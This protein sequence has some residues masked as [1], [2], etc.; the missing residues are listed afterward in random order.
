MARKKR[1]EIIH[2]ACA[3]LRELNPTS[4]ELEKTIF[5]GYGHNFDSFVTDNTWRGLK[6]GDSYHIHIGLRAD[7]YINEERVET[8][9]AQIKELR[10]EGI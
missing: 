2:E 10:K 1:S 8:L 3:Q 6:F 9:I 4:E 5:N 7:A